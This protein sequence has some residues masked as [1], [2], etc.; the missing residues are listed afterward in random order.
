MQKK[1]MIHQTADVDKTATIGDGTRIWH[2]SQLMPD[3]SIGKG[4]NL[5]K[6]VYIDKGVI[7]GDNVKIQNGVSV[8]RG[9]TIEANCFIG[10][11]ATF[12]NDLF[13]RALNHHFKVHK[14]LIKNGSSIGANATIICGIT[15]GEHAMVGAGSVVVKDVE[16]NSLV[17]GNPAKEIGKVCKCG[18]K[19]TI[20]SEK[21]VLITE[22]NSCLG[23]EESL[24]WLYYEVIAPVLCVRNTP[25][26]LKF[27]SVIMSASSKRD[28]DNYYSHWSTL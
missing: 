23:K 12:T 13:P 2:H 7:I 10:P 14:T 15:I 27:A 20:L 8:Y 19:V 6:G 3:C 16:K 24:G 11:N 21:N 22:C 4:C 25:E 9:V 18:E 26:I 28:K 17:V 5:G 1:I